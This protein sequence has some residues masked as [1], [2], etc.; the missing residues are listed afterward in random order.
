MPIDPAGDASLLGFDLRRCAR[1]LDRLLQ[2]RHFEREVDADRLVD[3]DVDR[4]AQAVREPGLDDLDPVG[5]RAEAQARGTRRR[6][7]SWRRAPRR[8]RCS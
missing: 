5:A 7:S 8:W 6:S 1:D 2:A 3:A 4:F